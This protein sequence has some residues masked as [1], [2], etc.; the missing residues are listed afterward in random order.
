MSDISHVLQHVNIKPE[1]RIKLIEHTHYNLDVGEINKTVDLLLI[2]QSSTYG[3]DTDERVIR[4]H[5]SKLNLTVPWAII[6]SN[7]DYF[8]KSEPNIIYY[9]FFLIDGIDKNKDIS[10][11]IKSSRRSIAS[12]LTFHLHIHRLLTFLQ[13]FKQPWFDRCLVNLYQVEKMTASQLH[14]YNISI[15]MLT[16]EEIEE[17]NE[18]IKIA[19]I[20]ADI[21]DKQEEIVNIKNTAFVDSYINIQTE[22]DYPTNFLT[23]KSIKPF[24]SGQFSAVL[25]HPKVYQHLVELGF[26]LLNDY[27]DL[28][29]KI[30]DIKEHIGYV[31]NQVTEL[32]TVIEQAWESSYTCRLHNYNLIRNPAL[33]NMLTS[34]LQHWLNNQGARQ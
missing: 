13:L 5:F 3:R 29:T 8:K 31:L 19:P 21:T 17:T 4:R 26:D 22:S 20:T 30:P 34:E 1:I 6:T 18:L 28:N 7:S 11:D 24:L 32:E 23:E 2:D 25:A 16:P 14:T 12:F 15:S 33:F 10:V 27:I 9:P